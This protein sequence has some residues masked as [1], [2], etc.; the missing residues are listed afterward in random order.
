MV[1]SGPGWELR[2]WHLRQEWKLSW[3][4]LC[5]PH[6]FHVEPS[7]THSLGSSRQKAEVFS[8]QIG[9][10]MGAVVPLYFLGEAVGWEGCEPLP[11]L[12]VGLCQLGL[13]ITVTQIVVGEPGSGDAVHRIVL[14]IRRRVRGEGLPVAGWAAG[15]RGTGSGP[16]NTSTLGHRALFKHFK[17]QMFPG[18]KEHMVCSW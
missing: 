6:L 17:T 2:A 4:R 18:Q 1:L 10:Q 9:C 7:D 8:M 5:F 14:I 16:K 15:K 13:C 11:R 3:Q 12:C